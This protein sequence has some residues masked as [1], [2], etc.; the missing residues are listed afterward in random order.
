MFVT[1][2][3][4]PFV[5]QVPVLLAIGA[6]VLALVAG[7][8]AC[9]RSIFQDEGAVIL[10]FAAGPLGFFAPL[11]YY[12]QAAPPLAM[13]T[14]SLFY[15]LAG[16]NIALT[17]FLLLLLTLLFLA[18][19][20]RAAM[21]VRDLGLL[22]GLLVLLA[23]RPILLYATE[24]KQYIF[25][26]IFAVALL[27]MHLARRKPYSPDW[28]FLFLV[29]AFASILFSFSSLF[30]IVPVMLDIIICRE[31][32][33]HRR[34][35]MGGLLL[36]CLGWVASYVWLVKPLIALQFINY[37]KEYLGLTLY[38][39]L[40]HRDITSL[41]IMLKEVRGI[42]PHLFL[43]VAAPVLLVAFIRARKPLQQSVLPPRS[44]LLSAPY[45]PLRLLVLV[46]G[47]L[48]VLNLA[49]AYPFSTTRQLLYVAPVIAFFLGWLAVR[50]VR[51]VTQREDMRMALLAVMV[52]PAMLYNLVVAERTSYVKTEVQDLYRFI[53]DHEYRHVV[54]WVIFDPTLHVFLEKDKTR[55]FDVRGLMNMAST[56]NI[57]VEE[58]KRKLAADDEDI[59]NQL[60]AILKR[61]E[62]FKPYVD[63]VVRRVQPQGVT[64][65]TT[66]EIFDWQEAQLLDALKAKGCTARVVFEEKAVKAYEARCG[67]AAAGF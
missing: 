9:R 3:P 19:A 54:S 50:M 1:P 43:V 37:G 15:S 35:W 48:G 57:S 5:R 40:L 66:V 56:P 28:L 25:E 34:A 52:L 64:L 23:V 58:L 14:L 29:V 46:C 7:G 60:W 59:P 2:V 20:M 55:Q 38:N 18:G 61:P 11:P 41:I 45:A 4:S 8:F 67:S 32:A 47:M 26:V 51:A 21:R 6:L 16:E 63:W 39:V 22:Y 44:D 30:I 42:G 17:R 53:G 24:L 62:D 27:M 33:G 13:G 12:D 31:N 36:F 65:I 10:N 49:G